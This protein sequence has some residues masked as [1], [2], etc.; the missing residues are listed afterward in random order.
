MVCP[1]ESYDIQCAEILLALSRVMKNRIDAN[2]A[3][4]TFIGQRLHHSTGS[5]YK[6]KL[7]YHMTTFR[8][9]K[10]RCTLHVTLA[11]NG[12]FFIALDTPRTI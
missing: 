3:E 4:R 12:L 5:A 1:K 11:L 6:R 8:A 10:T 9:G 7:G 2:A